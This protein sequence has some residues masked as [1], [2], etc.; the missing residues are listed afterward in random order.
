MPGP[1]HT[2]EPPY[3]ATHRHRQLSYIQD[4]ETRDKFVLGE[5][6][7]VEVRLHQRIN[8]HEAA[9][10]EQFQEFQEEVRSSIK[11]VMREAKSNDTQINK[12]VTAMQGMLIGVL[13]SL[14]VA[15]VVGALNLLLR[16]A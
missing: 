14:A 2:N 16:G 9:A 10:T 3:D 12:R 6:E 1:A 8:S 13:T 4:S 7:E 15:A 11:E 5:L